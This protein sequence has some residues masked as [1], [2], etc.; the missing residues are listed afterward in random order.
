MG[1]C[2]N[3][4]PSTHSLREPEFPLQFCFHTTYIPT[5]IFIQRYICVDTGGHVD[6]LQDTRDESV[7]KVVCS[8][9]N[10]R[11]LKQATNPGDYSIRGGARG[12]SDIS[13]LHIPLFSDI[14]LSLSVYVNKNK[15]RQIASFSLIRLTIKSYDVV[16]H[17][18]SSKPRII[19][20][21]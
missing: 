12:G 14:S 1:V 3:G 5:Y 6:F 20:W 21:H 4:G 16:L 11:A 19:R 13:T 7:R 17:F 8:C 18:S 10:A 9:A 15:Y 2:M